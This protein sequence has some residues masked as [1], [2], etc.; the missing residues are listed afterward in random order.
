MSQTK[1]EQESA[2]PLL[3]KQKRIPLPLP[4]LGEETFNKFLNIKVIEVI[5]VK[6]Q[7]LVW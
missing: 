5:I 1:G 4:G 2:P 3:E 7:T 6:H